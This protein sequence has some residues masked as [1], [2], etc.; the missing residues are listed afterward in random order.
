MKPITQWLL[1]LIL[2]P[3]W[4]G[5]FLLDRLAEQVVFNRVRDQLTGALYAHQ[6]YLL[7]I[8]AH[9][10]RGL[11]LFAASL[12]EDLANGRVPQVRHAQ[13][14]EILVEPGVSAPLVIG[15]TV[16]DPQGRLAA[17]TETPGPPI[18]DMAA[19]LRAGLA[20]AQVTE[21]KP[22]PSGPSTYDI[23]L[24]LRVTQ[25][26]PLLGVLGCRFRNILSEALAAHR[27]GLGLTGEV[28]LVS[29]K[30]KLMLTESRFI[31]NA[32][33]RVAVD[34][35]GVR[36][37]L[38]TKNGLAPYQD[39][40]G[41]PVI[42]TFL[43]LRD[44]DWVLLAEMDEEEALASLVRL[45]L[46]LVVSLGV[47]S[48]AAGFVGWRYGWRLGGA[49]VRLQEAKAN[50]EESEAQVR[51]LFAACI[52]AVIEIDERGTILLASE[53]AYRMFGWPAGALIGQS[54]TVLMPPAERDRHHAGLRRYLEAGESKLIGKVV[55][56]TGH[57]RDGTTFPCE[58]SLA[59]MT[60]P[61][62]TRRFVGVQRDITERKAMEQQARRLERLAALGQLLGGIA[63]ELRNPLF[64]LTGRLQLLR[65][66]LV[67][68][69]Y[70][71]LEPDLAKLEAA[72]QRMTAIAQ[73]FLAFARP[74]EPKL[75]RCSVHVVLQETLAFLANELIK[76]RIQVVT[77]FAPTLPSVRADPQQ[78]QEVFLNL[79][80]NAMQAM[81]T[82]HGQGTLTVSAA[83]APSDAE[84]GWI[85]I[86]IQDDGPGIPPEHR[87]K[88]FEPFF[89][90]K[91][92]D[93]GTGLGLWT[94]RTTLMTLKGTVTYETEVGHGTTFI[95]RLPVGEEPTRRQGGA[96]TG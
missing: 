11:R 2:I 14:L 6:Q 67:H 72:G 79:I 16:L 62:G 71:A 40:R 64:V 55:E 39:Y 18:S 32:I 94:V 49:M 70:G 12:V 90:T 84:G 9:Q 96:A 13:L 56:V 35:V 33:G 1:L 80:L 77:T 26:Q 61:D 44:Y 66:K 20:V 28:Y 63:H 36:E 34:T 10:Q 83:L 46:A 82:A 86:R 3:L 92:S 57:R 48:L 91:P 54:V 69:E 81:V 31:P 65:E 76:N 73:R 88:L 95:V 23:Y 74:Y 52:D 17:R 41:V 75:V 24:P 29:A 5:G 4:G 38:K 22:Q 37:A 8:L 45:R 7:T 43:Y 19:A 21:P 25:A 60:L 27:Q 53:A 78:L 50:A 58:L 87:T 51:T 85:E 42:G 68:H 59:A 30:T 89:T 93:Q 47:V 15:C